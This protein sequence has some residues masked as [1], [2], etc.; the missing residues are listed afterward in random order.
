MKYLGFFLIF[1]GAIDYGLS[2]LDIDLYA[3][4]G[5]KLSGLLYFLSPL[6]AGGF[7][8]L[9]LKFAGKKDTKELLDSLLKDGEKVSSTT[10]VNVKKGGLFGSI[11][12]GKFIV[13]NQQVIYIDEY[14]NL[15]F[16]CYLKDITSVKGSFNSIQI[17]SAG[18][19]FKFRP[20][21]WKVKKMVSEIKSY[22]TVPN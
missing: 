8:L 13:T 19:K 16:S 6:I 10:K 1:L 14:G 2:Q 17:E 15:E 12:T 22:A 5:I 18:E 11:E 4:F 9:L 3:L 21:F 7:G 20:G